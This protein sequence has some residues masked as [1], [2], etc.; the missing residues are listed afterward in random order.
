[1]LLS[2][3]DLDVT[4]D[5]L[6]FA[7]VTNDPM[8]DEGKHY[9]TLFTQASVPSDHKVRNMEPHKCVGWEWIHW[10]DLCARDDMF[11]PLLHITRSGFV[12][13]WDL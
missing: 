11:L 4:V 3:A 12:P 6:K 13:K 8:E 2:C 9:I 7:Y 5:K 10:T 1:M